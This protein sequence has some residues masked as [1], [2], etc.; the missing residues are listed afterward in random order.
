V[1]VIPNSNEQRRS[2]EEEHAARG[3]TLL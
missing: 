3:L 2:V 1:R